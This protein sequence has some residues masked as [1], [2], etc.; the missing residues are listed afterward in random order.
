M[1]IG[2]D[3]NKSKAIELVKKYAR[4]NNAREDWAA[5]WFDFLG[6]TAEAE[7]AYRAYVKLSKRDVNMLPLAAYLAK[8]NKVAEALALCEG[9]WGTAKPEAVARTIVTV[10]RAGEADAPNLTPLNAA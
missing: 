3:A 6:Q 4:S 5:R 1:L 8:N 2:K 10:V 7:A 9:A